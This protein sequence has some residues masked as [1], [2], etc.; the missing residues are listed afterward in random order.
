M[1][2]YK[3][4]ML[5]MDGPFSF[6]EQLCA[7]SFLDQ[8]H[9]VIL[10]TYGTVPNVPAGIE[11]RD[12]ADILP[13]DHIFI[14]ASSGSPTLHADLF[15][16]RLLEKHGDIVWAD[17][18]AYCLKPFEPMNGHYY[19]WGVA[20]QVFNGVMALPQDSAT[21]NGL[22][23]FTRD[24]YPIPPWLRPDQQAVLRAAHEAGTPVHVSQMVW[25][26]WGPQA[27]T[28]FL[29]QTGED[30]FAMPPNV[31]YPYPF[32]QRQ[33]LVRR[34]FHY[35]SFVTD[36]A[37]SIHF[38]GRFIRKRLS[39]IGGVPQKGTLLY[40]LAKKHDINPADAPVPATA[41]TG[42]KPQD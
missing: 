5:W 11:V 40:N 36:E 41:N 31:L 18:D 12:A 9:E 17:T 14:H 29:K 32:K 15:R 25:G 22:L 21:L 24:E 26:T 7:Q 27:L 28:W 39:M 35:N 23:D 33:L 8:G 10:Y 3:I 6:L 1:A 2:L 4:G 13:P 20:N 37:T 42:V 34:N 38:Y 19:S 16:Y 30:A